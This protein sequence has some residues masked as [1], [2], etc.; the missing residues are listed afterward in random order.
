[1]R[2]C[3]LNSNNKILI[4]Y[5]EEAVKKRLKELIKTMDFDAAWG[6]VCKEVKLETHKL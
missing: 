2:L 3:I 1:M 4:E 5:K 6:I